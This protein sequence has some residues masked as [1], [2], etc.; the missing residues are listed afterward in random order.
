MTPG[1]RRTT[2]TMLHLNLKKLVADADCF[3]EQTNERNKLMT[4]LERLDTT[5]ARELIY[6]LEESQKSAPE[7]LRLNSFAKMCSQKGPHIDQGVALYSEFDRVK[8]QRCFDLDNE[9]VLLSR[10]S[11]M[12][13]AAQHA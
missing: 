2:L 1:E 3:A 5:E 7:S 9:N 10:V 12:Q 11:Q 4:K 8:L 6:L 13:A